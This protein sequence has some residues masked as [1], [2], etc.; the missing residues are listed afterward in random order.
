MVLYAFRCVEGC[1]DIQQDHAMDQRPDAVPCPRC[2]AQARR[3]IGSPSLGRAD[4]AAMALHDAT[5]ATADRPQ[6][7]SQLPASPA[8]RPVTRNPAHQKLPRP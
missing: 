1:G 3:T 4:A 6:V 5:R 7:V 8:A 2:D